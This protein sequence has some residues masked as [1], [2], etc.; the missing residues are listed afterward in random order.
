MDLT[1]E[2]PSN[3]RFIG[4]INHDKW[5]AIE[6]KLRAVEKN[7]LFDPFWAAEI[8]LVLNIVVPK[9]FRV[10]DFIKYTGIECPNTHLWSYYNK[11]TKV[12][13]ND[14]ILIYFFEDNLTGS[15]LS[16]YMNLDNTKIKKWKDSVKAFLKQYKFNLQMD[17]DRTSLMTTEKGSYKLI[18]V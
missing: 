16:W 8:C 11:M 14:K 2:G 1:A 18:M 17:L 6:E 15:A 13:H 10:S 4:P 3:D 7:D 9:D 5:S 12:I